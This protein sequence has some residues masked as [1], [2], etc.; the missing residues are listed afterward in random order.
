MIKFTIIF[1]V[2]YYVFAWFT[3]QWINNMSPLNK[4]RFGMKNYTKKETIILFVLG[5]M[6]I[7]SVIF[8]AISIV[9]LACR[10]L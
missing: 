10:V 6:K 3:A 8:G 9:V 2:V 7:L 4:I 5:L 1:I